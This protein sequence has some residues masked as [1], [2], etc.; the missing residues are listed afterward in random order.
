MKRINNIIETESINKIIISNK[1]KASENINKITLKP[2]SGKDGIYYQVSEFDEKQVYH[3]NFYDI[4]TAWEYILNFFQNYK[5]IVIFTD[6]YDYNILIGKKGNITIKKNVPT[7]KNTISEH[8]KKKNY[9]IPDNKPCDFLFKLGI[10][11]EEGKVKA[12]KYDK[13]V[14]INKFLEIVSDVCDELPKDREI[15]IVDF[16]CGKSY[17]TFALYYYFNFVKSRK[18][19]IIGVDLKEKV[20]EDCRR[21]AQ[22]IGYKKMDF[23]C[24]DIK[25]Y[26]NK[27]IDM[28]VSLHA[29]DTATDMALIKA[30]EWKSK[31][32]ISV[33][34][35][36]HELFSQIKSNTL[37]P[38]IRYGVLKDKVATIVTDTLRSLALEINGYDVSVIEF[39]PLEHTAKNVMIRAILS[40][41]I[42]P[43]ARKKYEE[44]KEFWNVNPTADK[45]VY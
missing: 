26:Y 32:I 6:K 11:T 36:H 12:Q 21:I 34:C 17:I 5:N 33:P 16:G 39:T 40:G 27:D 42:N 13:F 9:I 8:N 31:V 4:E 28:V 7:S 1:R 19:H 20:I 25:D 14:Q 22:E 18:V 43:L 35:C 45:L 10:M 15:S 38:M 44:L 41:K 23:V 24:G 2:F 37:E 30:V 29:C 3:K